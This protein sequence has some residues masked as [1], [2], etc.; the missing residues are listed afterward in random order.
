MFEKYAELWYN[1]HK[2]I[3]TLSLSN[4]INREVTG[5]SLIYEPLV[6]AGFCWE[7]LKKEDHLED[8]DLNGGYH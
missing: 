5:I 7:N 8:L 4:G 3:Y 1:E 2:C 6:H